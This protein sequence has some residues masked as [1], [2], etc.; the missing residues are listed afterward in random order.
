MSICKYNNCKIK[1][2]NNEY[3]YKHRSKNIDFRKLY[4]E[5]CSEN[6]EL[7]KKI[8]VL[9]E[10]NKK[11]K[12]KLESNI[13][14]KIQNGLETSEKI[15]SPK[16]NKIEVKNNYKKDSL[17]VNRKEVQSHGFFWEKEIITKVYGVTEDEMKQIKYNSKMDVPSVFNHI[18]KYDVSI[19]TTNNKN[20]VCMA[21]CL[22]IFDSVNCSNPFRLVV[23][24][25][26]QN[27]LT[28][29]KIK[30]IVEIDLTSSHDILFG[31]IKRSQIEE[32][33]NIVKSVPNNRKP[34]KEEHK[35]MYSYRDQLKNLSGYIYFNIKCNS[36]QSRLQCSF[37]NFEKFMEKNPQRIISKSDGNNFMGCVI[38][39]EIFS[40]PRIF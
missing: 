4:E 13:E 5:K 6:E 32:L 15:Y 17:I 34:T 3:C 25:Y 18:G 8:K 28:T 20:T 12:E 9:E 7:H 29:K 39:D 36:T 16:E 22:R 11:Y 2:R 23:V 1:P 24:N 33:N 35:R 26:Y 10:E 31:Q 27:T 21:D 40:T 14:K 37:N 19:K 30:N 38:S